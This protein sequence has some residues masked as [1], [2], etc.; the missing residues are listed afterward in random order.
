MFKIYPLSGEFGRVPH[1]IRLTEASMKM[2]RAL[3]VLV[4]GFLWLATPS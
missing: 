2:H 1:H 4:I 3:R